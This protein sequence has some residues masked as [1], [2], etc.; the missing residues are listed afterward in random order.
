MVS[1][2][3]NEEKV[4]ESIDDHFVLNEIEIENFPLPCEK[5]VRD[6]QGEAIVVFWRVIYGRVNYRLQEE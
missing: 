4:M 1:L 6:Q 5:L 2:E 3:E